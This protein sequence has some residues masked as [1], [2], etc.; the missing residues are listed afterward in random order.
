M[1]S[2]PAYMATT[3]QALPNQ[4]QTVH[5]PYLAAPAEGPIEVLVPPEI[6]T[7]IPS[8]QPVSVVRTVTVIEGGDYFRDLYVPL[9]HVRL[10]LVLSA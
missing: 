6:V 8:V 2:V 3:Y 10:F 5:S 7:H 9:F 1:D 4:E